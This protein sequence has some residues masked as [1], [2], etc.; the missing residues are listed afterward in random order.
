MLSLVIRNKAAREIAQAREYYS[1]HNRG[2][3]FISALE[4]VFRTI[5]ELP[6]AA[7]LMTDE[8][9]RSILRKYPYGVFYVVEDSTVIVLAV[10]HQK[11]D[12]ASWP[13]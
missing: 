13:R 2:E 3:Y 11:H 8:V 4:K 9:R 7:P 10:L 6:K 1:V 12:P 5:I